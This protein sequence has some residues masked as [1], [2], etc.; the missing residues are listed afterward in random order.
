MDA[1]VKTM[2]NLVSINAFN[3]GEASKIFDM[4]RKTNQ[5]KLVLKRNEPECIL[6]S[7][8]SYSDMVRELEDLRDYKMAIERLAKSDG[9]TITWEKLKTTLKITDE[10]LDEIGDIEFE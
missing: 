8:T 10:E 7:P 9:K 2:N 1:M 5:P 3:R 6:L 4:V